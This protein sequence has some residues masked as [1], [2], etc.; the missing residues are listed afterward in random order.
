MA[1][2]AV[3]RPLTVAVVVTGATLLP[4]GVADAAVLGGGNC[5]G[6]SFG[7]ILDRLGVQLGD[8]AAQRGQRQ[9]TDSGGPG[10]NSP[11][12]EDAAPCAT[13]DPSDAPG[14]EGAPGTLAHPLPGRLLDLK[15]WK[16][17]LPT[18][19]K[20]KPEEIE[21]P[22]LSAF[23]N[24]FFRLND[25]K[26]G[27]VFTANAGGV[28]TSG[29]SYPRSELREMNGTEKAAWDSTD[30]THTLD[31]CEAITKTPATKPEVVSAQIH[32]TEDD[33]LQIRLEGTT[34][35]V[36]YDDGRGEA[37]LDP[38]YQLGTPFRVTVDVSAEGI[39]VSYNGEHKTDIK[40]SGSGWYWKV[41]AY[42]QSN[43]S[44]GESPDA[45]GEVVVYS[46]DMK[47]DGNAPGRPAES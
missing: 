31:V 39:A 27:V 32:D 8:C 44:K 33:V 47:Q 5:V 30:G 40:K 2:S 20:G 12:G 11:D 15:N 36:Q 42:V 18:G 10:G 37:V 46:L 19:R 41:G 34:L 6:S 14:E 43:P 28:T 1:L 3:W 24:D 9:T 21:G 35:S 45:V 16:L 13:A 26:D 17:T 23:T 25:A 38:D 22:D 7:G 4:Q 29:S